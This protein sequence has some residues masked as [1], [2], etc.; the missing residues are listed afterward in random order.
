MFVV[1]LS[2]ELDWEFESSMDDSVLSEFKNEE[3]AVTG[4]TAFI[5][6]MDIGTPDEDDDDDDD[7]DDDEPSVDETEESETLRRVFFF[8]IVSSFFDFLEVP[9][10]AL[11]S[12]A[13]SISSITPLALFGTAASLN[14][15]IIAKFTHHHYTIIFIQ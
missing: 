1:P 15:L 3:L 11:L 5:A 6:A 13:A 14:L 2:S 10:V 9:V 7:D 12:A 8:G 4:A